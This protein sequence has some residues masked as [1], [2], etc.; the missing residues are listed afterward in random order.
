MLLSSEDCKYT[1]TFWDEES[2]LPSTKYREHKIDDNTTIKYRTKVSGRYSDIANTDLTSFLLSRLEPIGIVSLPKGVKIA[3]YVKGDYFEPHHDFNYNG[4]GAQYKTL[5]IQLSDP[6][7]YI[8]GD[9]YV[10]GIPQSR[11]QGDYALFFSSDIHEVKIVEEGIRY[12]LTYFLDEKNF[13]N[14][15]TVI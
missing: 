1:L 6:S 2:S 3:R 12:S 10:K 7:T 9:L 8:G 13:K 5:V 11:I 4:S 15:K 14:T